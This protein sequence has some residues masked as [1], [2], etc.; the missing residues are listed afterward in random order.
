MISSEILIGLSTGT[1]YSIFALSVVIL[2]KTTGQVNFAVGEV[3]MVP[4]FIGLAVYD[5]FHLPY[6]VLAIVVVVSAALLSGAINLLVIRPMGGTKAPHTQVGGVTLGISIFLAAL[7]GVIWGEDPHA[8]PG[9]I[10]GRVIHLG[11][12][13][14][15]TDFAVIIPIGALMVV[16]TYLFL[17]RSHLG[18]QMR[19]TSEDAEAVR[20]MGVSPER[21]AMVAWLVAG[22]LSGLAVLLLAPIAF[23]HTDMTSTIVIKSFAATVIGGLFSVPGAVVGGLALGLGETV[24]AIYFGQSAKDALAFL[25]ILVVLIIKPEGM[26]GSKRLRRV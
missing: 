8:F 10:A 16:L 5:R 21:V 11:G 7:A 2:F 17:Y 24:L 13:M 18:L 23:V 25:L 14:V 26:L 6:P 4:A 1:L 19:A 12:L 3:G 15:Q 20:I 9:P 22:A